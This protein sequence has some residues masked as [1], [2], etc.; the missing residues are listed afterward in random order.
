MVLLALS[1]CSSSTAENPPA[2]AAANLI[3]PG[4]MQGLNFAGMT[5]AQKTT[6]V[7]VLN[8]EGCP[9]GCGMNLA[10]CRRDDS[11]CRTSLG[12]ASQVL[13]LAKQDKTQAQIVAAVQQAA[14]REGEVRQAQ[15][16]QQQPQQQQG[17]PPDKFVEF[18]I[19]D[20]GAPFHGTDNA[21]VTILHYIDYQ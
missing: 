21:P 8:T 11:T 18:R 13:A 19:P 15:K 17:Q 7:Q 10:T 16:P 5:E 6:A 9:C 14:N 12:I 3:P 2:A 1:A 20:G 4:D